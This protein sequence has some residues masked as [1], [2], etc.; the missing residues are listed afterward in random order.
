[1]GMPE[2]EV[3]PL[4]VPLITKYYEE[5]ENG[6]KTKEYR[7]YGPRWNERTCFVGRPAVLSK[8]YGKANRLQS[9]VR[10]FRKVPASQYPPDIQ[11]DIITCFGGLDFDIAEI[12]FDPPTPNTKE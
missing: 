7:K 5:F 9:C 12:E 8:G 10:N 1:M 2:V 6:T 3:R 11:A 4:F